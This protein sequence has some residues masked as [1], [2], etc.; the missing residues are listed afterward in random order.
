[1]RPT[2]YIHAGMH[3]TGTTSIQATLFHNRRRLLRHDVNYLSIAQNHSDML[4]TLLRED[5]HRWGVNIR[6]GIDTEQKV[7]RYRA[8][9]DAALRR[10]LSRNTCSKVIISGEE[11]LA[12]SP[13]AT[14]ALKDK[15]AP[16][17]DDIRVIVYVREPYSYISSAFAE[18]LRHGRD[19][20]EL[21][22]R[23]GGPNY[24]RIAKLIDVFGRDHVDIRVFDRKRFPGG[25]LLA[26]FCLAIGVDPDL[27]RGLAPVIAN[28]GLSHEATLI[29]AALN[30]V[31]PT[32]R[33]EPLNRNVD[34]NIVTLLQSIKG[35]TFRCPRVVMERLQPK[36]EKDVAWLNDAIGEAVFSAELPPDEDIP[37]G[38][39]D[40]AV[41]SLA[42]A[43][44]DLAKSRRWGLGRLLRPEGRVSDTQKERAQ[45]MVADWMARRAPI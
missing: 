16:Y 36:V 39:S 45:R 6:L 29:F 33:H 13:E 22:G 44:N 27:L 4:M 2:I 14:A 28:E 21:L 38:W 11:I 3:K 8:A 43:L 32:G 17:A 5:A 23:A 35:R 37:Q 18:Q 9:I 12:F 24:R 41:Q 7:A 25:D 30:R 40:E 31:Y 15:L 19:W 1:M 34:P 10:E 42:V 20:D 26:D